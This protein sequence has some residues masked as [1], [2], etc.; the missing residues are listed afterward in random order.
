MDKQ[1][2]YVAAS[3]SREETFIYATPGDSDP[4]RGDRARNRPTCARASRTSPKPPS[5]TAR[6]SQRT[7]G[8]ALAVLRPADRGAGRKARRAAGRSG[9]GGSP[10]RAQRRPAGADRA[11]PRAALSATRRSERQ[12]KALPRRE[13]KDELARIDTMKSASRRQHRRLE[14]E[15][16]GDARSGGCCAAGVRRRRS[17]PRR[18]AR[19][20]DHRRPHLPA[21][22]HHEGAGGEAR[23]IRSSGRH[24]IAASP[25]SSATA[26]STASRT[27]AKPLAGRRNEEP[28]ERARRQRGGGSWR[29]SESSASGSTRRERASS[30]E[31]LSIGR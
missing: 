24:G 8:A 11:G 16:R 6:S 18:A 12:P 17:G 14:A 5:A 20:G 10:A 21:H 13:R 25:R 7:T 15:L 22:L 28:S 30:A 1:E 9:P 3:R 2:L 23:A 31:G 29:F 4:P 27:R 19:A 26:R